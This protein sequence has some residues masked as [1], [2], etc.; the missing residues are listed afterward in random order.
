MNKQFSFDLQTFADGPTK[1]ANVI[2]P[3]VM[4]D[5]VS[6]GLP[7]AIK[8]TPIAKIDDTLTGAP[9]N[10]ITIPAWGYIGDAEDI[11]EGVEVTA[12]QMSA[13]TIKATIKKAMKR[14]DI[15]DESKLSGYGDPVGEATHQLRLSL[16]SKI[17]QDVVAVLGGATL[18]ITDTKAISYAGVV[19]AVDKLNE[20]DYVEKYL[21]VAPSQITALRKDPD[22][23]DKTKYGNDVMMTGEIGMIAGCRVVTSRR[24][25]DSKANIDN[26][27]VGV[28]A[29]VEDGTPV[30]PAVTIYIKRDV[31]IE[32]DRV[33]E[34]GLDK[35]VANEHYVAALTNQSKVV[36][37][38]FKK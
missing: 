12:T 36:K 25:D 28:T 2:N 1:T 21:F 37:A 27:I 26:F 34:K 13:S 9:G 4:A 8:F 20:E 29:E 33:P 23:I 19:N 10:E 32:T 35:I 14:V 18:T 7:K 17:D 15:T 30:L 16:A 6:A 11:A 22:F 3:Q 24:I 38:T 31:M 5:M